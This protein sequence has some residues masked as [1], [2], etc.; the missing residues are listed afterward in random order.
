MNRVRNFKGLSITIFAV[1]VLFYWIIFFLYG[2]VWVNGK[3]TVA[4]VLNAVLMVGFVG[5]I[6]TALWV[7]TKLKR[8]FSTDSSMSGIKKISL[9]VLSSTILIIHLTMW[10]SFYTN[11]GYSLGGNFFITDKKQV[12]DSYYLYIVR[13]K[14]NLKNTVEIEC[15]KD[16]YDNLI[17]NEQV[18]YGFS[19]RCLT[20]SENKG[21]LERDINTKDFID[22]RGK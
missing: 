17:V 8:D 1:E 5:I 14:N 3:D 10:F 20:Y 19:Y 22:N 11:M 18:A 4:D 9:V 2:F 6:I 13:H 16:T 7:I 12:G 21:V 15:S